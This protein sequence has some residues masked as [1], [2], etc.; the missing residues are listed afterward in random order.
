MTVATV[1]QVGNAPHAASVFYAVDEKLRLY[2]LSRPHSIHAGHI[3]EKGPVAVTVTEEYGDWKMIQGVQLWGDAWPLTGTAKV[4]ALAL[5]VTR[6][7]FVRDL[8]RQPRLAETFKD[9]GVYVVEPFRA[10][11]TDNT[12]GVFGREM[13]ELEVE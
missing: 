2:F 13:L 9:I 3:G 8:L 12:T 11:F 4:T 7:P 10:A 5:Y 1:A 6:F